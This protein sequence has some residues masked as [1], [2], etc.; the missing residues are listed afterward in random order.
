[1]QQFSFSPARDARVNGQYQKAAL[2]KASGEP[3]LDRGGV[4]TGQLAKLCNQVIVG[5]SVA[6][7]AEAL[8]LARAG[9]AD[10]AAVRRALLGG[11]ANST[12]LKL[13]GERMATGNFVPGGP[14]VYQV[15]DLTTAR[16]LA[17]GYGLDLPLLQSAEHL[18]A[19]IVEH[20]DGGLDHS[21]VIL[22]IARRT[23]TKST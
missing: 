21:G 15:K 14:A 8:Y 2:L 3:F 17:E 23:K 9:E 11:F 10:V 1:M 4:G 7:V 16:T 6:A 5:I 13:H 22:E 18:F 20:G 12:I 19:D